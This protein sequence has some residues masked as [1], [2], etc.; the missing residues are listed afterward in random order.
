MQPATDGRLPS[1]E[2]I[3]LARKAGLLDKVDLSED[4]FIP[5]LASLEEIDKFA[6]LVAERARG[7][8]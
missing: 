3:D 6:A 7:N 5:A 8:S 1:R 4:Y 2:V